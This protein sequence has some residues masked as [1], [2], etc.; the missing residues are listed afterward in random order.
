M[1]AP[2]ETTST[3][4][5]DGL[6]VRVAR[7]RPAGIADPP[8][9]IVL[10]GWG[11]HIEA[12]GSILAGLRDQVE[13]IAPDLPG[14][15]RSD[16]VPGAWTNADY[17]RFVV[18]LA[19]ALGIGR[20]ALIGHSRGAAIALVLATEPDSR[21]R[22]ERMVFTGAA[23]IKPRR[24]A[25]YYGKVGMAKV[26]KAAAKVGGAPGRKLQESIRG[27]V[28]SADWLAA[29]EAL[30]G[31]LRNVLAEDLSPRLPQVSAP[32]L[33]MW[34]DRDDDTP[35]WMAEKMEREIPGAGL[36]VLRGGGHYAYA[37]QAGQFNVVAAHFL[38]QGG[39]RGGAAVGGADA[40][41]RAGARP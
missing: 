4:T 29:P 15:G 5:V 40:D 17:A 38:T 20:F 32:T 37:E 30:R 27:R 2:S 23:G 9:V 6:R 7:T 26:G 11:A 1:P 16:M 41:A 25:A 35:M 19:D 22:V 3:V 13:L 24:R 10:H 33:L 8:V 34:G 36:V 18:K 31:T 12:L 28:A 21:D 14:H 39:R